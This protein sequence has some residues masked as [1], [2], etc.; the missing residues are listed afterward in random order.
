MAK[1][2][3]AGAVRAMAQHNR[4]QREV[5][6][7]ERKGVIIQEHPY[8][9]PDIYE[10]WKAKLGDH[11]P[12][13]NAV[14]GVEVVITASPHWWENTNSN[15][16][17]GYIGDS[18]KWLEKQFGHQNIVAVDTHRDEKTPHLHAFIIPMKDGKLNARHFIG[19]SRERMSELQT[20]FYEQVK[21][22]SLERGIKGSKAKHQTLKRYYATVKSEQK[23]LERKVDNFTKR[24]I[25]KPSREDIERVI[26]ANERANK[27]L[28]SRE[29]DVNY[30]EHELQRKQ[31]ETERRRRLLESELREGKEAKKKVRELEKIIETQ[32]DYTIDLLHKAL[33]RLGHDSMDEMNIQHKIQERERDRG[34]SL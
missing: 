11:R 14:Y 31:A 5:E 23:E 17:Q 12:R 26:V 19:G 6:N 15:T 21:N 8:D 4:R 33:T 18:I 32:K 2:K 27:Q 24:R 10:A 16:Q 34:M 28:E 13:T 3:S 30:G 25:R 1:V 20:S 7:A 9:P 29:G 22:Y